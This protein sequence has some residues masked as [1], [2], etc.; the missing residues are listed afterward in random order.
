MTLSLFEKKLF[1]G[2]M[3]LSGTQAAGQ[4]CSM[5]RNIIVARL[6]SPTDFG[7]AAIFLMTVNLMDII[8]NMSLDRLL[9]QAEDGDMEAFQQTAQ[10]INVVRG[11]ISALL[12]ALLAY[13]MAYLFNIPEAG[14]AFA[15]LGLVPLVIGFSHLDPKRVERHMRF[16]PNSSV[17]VTSQVLLLVAA[18]PLATYFHDYRAMLWLLVLR[19]IVMLVGS[20][21]V[22]ERPYTLGW[23]QNYLQRFFK[24]GWP[25]LLNGM[26][27]F[28]VL[29]GDRFLLGS[30]QKLFGSNYVM[31]DVG[32]YS[33]AFLAV[34][35]P[36]LLFFRAGNVFLPYLSRS[37]SNIPEFVSKFNKIIYIYISMSM[38]FV[39]G[40]YFF[41]ESLFV[42]FFGNKYAEASRLIIVFATIFSLQ[43]FRSSSVLASLSLGDSKTS[44]YT[45]LIR[46]FYIFVSIVIVYNNYSYIYIPFSSLIFESIAV[47][48]T[49]YRLKNIHSINTGFNKLPYALLFFVPLIMSFK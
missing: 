19:S 1:R 26:L 7:I 39:L 16:W 22:A 20:H 14:M 11:G 25:L 3:V 48:F 23:Q 18:W 44:M 41:G 24:F 17:E 43:I 10:G 40:Y 46:S 33:A 37:Q 31:A 28:L 27:L 5:G 2:A 9:V 15:C 36:A 32:L 34:N 49:S 6:L 45:T 8:S 21:L 47:I 30:A 4:V 12:L 38:S 35:S 42:L 29:Q 13:P